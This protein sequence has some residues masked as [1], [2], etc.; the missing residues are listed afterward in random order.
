[1]CSSICS[2]TPPKRDK[3]HEVALYVTSNTV[4]SVLI[5]RIQNAAYSLYNLKVVFIGKMGMPPP[6]TDSVWIAD[7]FTNKINKIKRAKKY[8]YTI[9]ITDVF[10][11]RIYA[12]FDIDTFGLYIKPVAGYSDLPHNSCVVSRDELKDYESDPDSL[13]TNR[14][15]NVAMHELGHLVGLSHCDSVNCLMIGEGHMDNHSLCGRCAAELKD[16]QNSKPKKSF[17]SSFKNK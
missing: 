15:V 11:V 4:D 17:F 6:K 2:A 3:R 13:N 12:M 9:A 8:K 7:A 16:I 10:L 5:S 1:M 14:T